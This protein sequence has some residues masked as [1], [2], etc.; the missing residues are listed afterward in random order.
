MR[1]YAVRDSLLVLFC[2]IVL[3]WPLFRLKYLDD[4]RS[5]ESTFIADAR[6]TADHLPHTGWQPLWYCGTRFDYVYP[7]ALRY[8]PALLSKAAHMTTA[9]AYHLYTAIL[10]V[11][12]M[13]SVYW[14]VRIGSGSRA[15]AFLATAAAALLSP[16]LL[17][18]RQLHYDSPLWVP[19]RL[20][21]LMSYGEGPHMSALAILPAALAASWLAVRQW[22]PAALVAAG[23]LCALV[24][25]HN[26]YGATA[27][28]ITFPILIWSV[29]V[30]ELKATIWL[31][32]AAIAVLAC[33]LCAPW[34]TPSYIRI[35]L[36]D[37]QWVSQPGNPPL[38]IVFALAVLTY[39]AFSYRL[40]R[41]RPERMWAVFVT[42]LLLVIGIDVLG[43]YYFNARVFGEGHR[44]APEFDLAVILAGVEIVRR[45]WTRPRLRTT[46]V[47]VVAIAFI[48]GTV[49]LR[50]AWSPFPKLVAPESGYPWKI[51]HWVHDNM[52]GQRSLPSGEV[53]FW[54]DAW[55]DNAQLDGGS[56]QG[57]LNQT[58]PIATYQVWNGDN[59]DLSVHWLQAMGTDA[60]IVPGPGSPDNYRTDYKFP[61]KF[62]G[63]LPVLHEELDTT[64]YRVPRVYRSI[65]RVV[66]RAALAAIGTLKYSDP[67]TV[68]HYADLVEDPSQPETKIVWHGFDEL[69]VT[70]RVGA[71][72]SILVQETFDSAWHAYEN[73][74]PVALRIEPHVSFMLIDV[75]PGD[76][77][78]TLKFETPPENQAGLGIFG[79]TVLTAVGLLVIGGRRRH[80]P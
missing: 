17:L 77:T 20:H 26:F 8:G 51:A 72:Q 40:G 37:M 55:H 67:P 30:G 10:Y 47:A 29:W 11:L 49:Y 43:Y 5:I 4:W 70:A 62:R 19:Q 59:A 32:A 28:A 78:I 1:K 23:L 27:L 15:G 65:G 39:C 6:I 54:F 13:L 31:R 75:M 38:Q 74:N 33:G 58:I 53:R 63:I 35:T 34:L 60:V 48:P 9:R 36:V 50:H 16:I 76:H 18:V 66:D 57:M 7:P 41:H 24:V 3:I 42:G 2:S 64:I 69:T 14:F 45:G 71:G 21:V 79:V 22:R 12:G 56:M 44:L 61:N 80:R 46:L 25:M 73:G 52:P 68:G